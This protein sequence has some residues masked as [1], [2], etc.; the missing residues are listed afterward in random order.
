[1]LIRPMV[2]A[3]VVAVEDLETQFPSPWTGKQIFAELDRKSGIS[4]IAENKEGVVGWCCGMATAPEAELFKI[5]VAANRQRRGVAN[6]LLQ[7][8]VILLVGR[9][10]EQIYLE[11]RSENI[12]ARALYRSSGWKEQGKRKNY[13]TNPVDDAILLV[14]NLAPVLDGK[15]T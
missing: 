2:A 9:R 5:A 4:L 14:R 7:E 13:Y 11:V 15:P 8:L 6:F 10:V 12:P 1:M 3:D